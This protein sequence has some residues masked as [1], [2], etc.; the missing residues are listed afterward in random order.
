MERMML[1]SIV[2]R[3]RVFDKTKLKCRMDRL[4][5]KLNAAILHDRSRPVQCT[6]CTFKGSISRE[7]K[8]GI[9]DILHSCIEERARTAVT[10]RSPSS[11]ED[12]TCDIKQLTLVDHSNARYVIVAI[13]KHNRNNLILA[14]DRIRKLVKTGEVFEIP[15]GFDP[16][17]YLTPSFGITV[18]E[19]LNVQI[20]F[21]VEAAFHIRERV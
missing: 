10:C 8:E 18:E 19:P 13:P 15:D 5:A 6:V 1:R 16:H 3:T 7:G 14:V 9:I 11:A 17:A 20:R 2:E 12:T 4:R 21:T